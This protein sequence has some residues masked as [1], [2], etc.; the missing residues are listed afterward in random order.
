[1]NKF[2]KYALTAV[3]GILYKYRIHY[4]S[5]YLKLRAKLQKD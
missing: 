4:Y 3:I 1:M 5:F 2:I